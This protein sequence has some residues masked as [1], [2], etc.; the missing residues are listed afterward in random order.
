MLNNPTSFYSCYHSKENY[1]LLPVYQ[2]YSTAKTSQMYQKKIA[3][4]TNIS[5]EAEVI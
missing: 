3:M 2:T 5:S 4:I 1:N